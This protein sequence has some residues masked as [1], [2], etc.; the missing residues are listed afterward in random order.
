MLALD[1]INVACQL[2]F[3]NINQHE[4]SKGLNGLHRLSSND[5][6]NSGTT[7]R[8]RK[9]SGKNP[10][11]E[12]SQSKSESACTTYNMLHIIWT[13]SHTIFANIRVK[14]NCTA[15]TNKL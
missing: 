11:S 3:I 10:L 13:I 12:Q 14:N 5:G 1:K 7:K 4:N 15:L 9:A 6:R 2:G 8:K